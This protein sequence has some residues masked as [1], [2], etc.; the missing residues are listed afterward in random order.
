MTISDLK[1]EGPTSGLSKSY[2]S[3]NCASVK[4]QN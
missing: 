1:G 4:K 2:F 3:Y